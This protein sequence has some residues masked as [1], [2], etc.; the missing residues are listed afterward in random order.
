MIFIEKEKITFFLI[1]NIN[2]IFSLQNIL[3]FGAVDEFYISSRPPKSV[4]IWERILFYPFLPIVHTKMIKNGD[5]YL[6][7]SPRSNL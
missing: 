5:V 6:R 4:F 7:R 2:I 3:M 1:K